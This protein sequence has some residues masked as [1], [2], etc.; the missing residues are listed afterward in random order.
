MVDSFHYN[1]FPCAFNA[2]I[3]VE[4]ENLE[5]NS[6]YGTPFDKIKVESSNDVIK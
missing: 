5:V 4:S 1:F 3:R 2:Y 6:I